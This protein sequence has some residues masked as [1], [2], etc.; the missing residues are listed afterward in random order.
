[1]T[2]YRDAITKY[3]YH[4]PVQVPHLPGKFD[5]LVLRGLLLE[6]ARQRTVDALLQLVVNRLAEQDKIALAR[7]WLIAPGDICAT[8]RMR[9][10]CPDRTSC[11]H[12]AASAGHSLHDEPAWNAID[13]NFRR[14]PV[15]VR[16]VGWIAANGEPIEVENV[17][18]DGRWIA[19]PAWV[20]REQIQGF[21]GQPL[22]YRDQVLGV[23]GVFARA[24]MCSDNLFWLRGIAD[25]AAT[26]IAN[27]RAFEEIETLQEKLEL[28]NEYLREEV[29]SSQGF[30]DIVGKSD[31]LHRVLSQVDLV[32]PADTSV[33]ISGESGTGKELIARAIHQRSRRN[34]RPIIK[35]NCASI[36]R[37]L[38]ES[39]FFGHVKGAFTGAIRDRVGRFQ[40][41]DGGTLFLD[42]V[43][44]I[45]LELQSKL[46]RVIQEGTFERVGDD[47]TRRVDVRLVAAT[48]RDLAQQVAAGQ[49]REDLY[50]RL[51]VFPVQVPP[52]RQRPDDIPLL[53]E[54]F[55]ASGAASMGLPVPTLKRRHAA[56]LQAYEWPG[57]VRELQNVVER[58]LL[59]TRTGPL[60]FALPTAKNGD[61]RA[62]PP[63]AP[64]QSIQTYAQLRE[65]ERD[66][67]RRALEA[68]HWRISGPGGAAQLLGLRP[69]TLTSKL[70]SLGLSRSPQ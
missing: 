48:N 52:L 5:P 19:K 42:E 60:E 68:T 63:S 43:A 67:V 13:G 39:E 10:E 2:S 23:L 62:T 46:L 45:P 17:Q 34:D 11:L 27:A 25:L 32:A 15:G 56:E 51:S 28:E 4:D 30:G 36:P 61:N 24:P 54:H 66:N 6:M 64:D 37:D 1:M 40:L 7:I 29:R 35:V 3:R 38:F 50:Y 14:F 33:L 70:K 26:T 9:P 20:Q 58:A 69:T 22:L 16:K 47:R 12:L 44:E 41:A 31:A 57:N 55:L 59:A 65:L 21:G 53:A 18:T 8:C 49:F